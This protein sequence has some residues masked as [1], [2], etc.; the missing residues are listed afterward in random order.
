MTGYHL[1]DN[2][3]TNFPIRIFKKIFV[4]WLDS[5]DT[6]R[7]N[8]SVKELKA[9]NLT[10]VHNYKIDVFLNAAS[11]EAWCANHVTATYKAWYYVLVAK[12]RKCLFIFFSVFMI[13]FFWHI[14]TS[15]K[16]LLN[17]YI[18]APSNKVKCKD[19]IFDRMTKQMLK[20]HGL[21]SS[22]D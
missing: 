18:R 12:W 15:K 8:H 20:R 22:H 16:L 5:V 7:E 2:L 10:V 17:S 9:Q 3:P 6:L 11:A 4:W 14:C 21:K 13:W 19:Q 1:A